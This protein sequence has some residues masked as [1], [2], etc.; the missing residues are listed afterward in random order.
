MGS[1]GDRA[2]LPSPTLP[3]GICCAAEKLR[4]SWGRRGVGRRGGRR[5]GS[6]R[7]GCAF[8]STAAAWAGRAQHLLGGR[9]QVHKSGG[10]VCRPMMRGDGRGHR[11]LCP[12]SLL[13]G[14]KDPDKDEDVACKQHTL[15]RE[16]RSG[17]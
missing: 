4:I 9:E 3:I 2:T 8:L 14:H 17:E 15:E 12:P 13:S 10:S 1:E 7:P 5:G 6:W 11:V 16:E